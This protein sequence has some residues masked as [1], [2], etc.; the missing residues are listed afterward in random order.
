MATTTFRGNPITLDAWSR[1]YE[2]AQKESFFGKIA[3]EFIPEFNI[4]DI[5]NWLSFSQQK[6][7]YDMREQAKQQ[8]GEWF[9]EKL[10]RM[11]FDEL[12]TFKN[13]H[14]V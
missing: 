6:S 2:E 12:T 10:D 9:Q 11:M 1:M 14:F 5:K 13:K 4:K 8:L 3:M 7:A